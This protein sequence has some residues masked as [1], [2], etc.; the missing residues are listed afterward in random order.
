MGRIEKWIYLKIWNIEKNKNAINNKMSTNKIVI[1][2]L[3]T[4][5]LLFYII[6][7]WYISCFKKV[8]RLNTIYQNSEIKE[9]DLD[10]QVD[11]CEKR[12]AQLIIWIKD[13]QDRIKKKKEI[14]QKCTMEVGKLETD[15]EQ[16]KKVRGKP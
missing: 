2:L 3:L 13:N 8:K 1:L 14:L 5:V 15:L 11:N 6:E 10:T 16:L 9:L 12:K 7:M 4:I